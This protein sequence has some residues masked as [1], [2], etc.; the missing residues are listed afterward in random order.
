MSSH[1]KNSTRFLRWNKKAFCPSKKQYGPGYLGANRFRENKKAPL[2]RFFLSVFFSCIFIFRSHST[3]DVPLLF[4]GI[5][6]L[7]DLP[8]KLWVYFF[9]PLRYI[10]MYGAFA[11]VKRF[12]RTAYSGIILYHIQ[13]QAT[14]S[15]QSLPADAAPATREPVLPHHM[16]RI[17]SNMQ[18]QSRF[19]KRTALLPRCRGSGSLL[20]AGLSIV[21]LFCYDGKAEKTK[22]EG[23]NGKPIHI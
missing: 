6:Q 16:Q 4:I 3:P 17:G 7:F 2:W 9:Q 20:N 22:K 13:P 8:V 21:L 19:P 10:F 15:I 23:K 1:Q 11:D 12:R 14:L 18:T 5:H